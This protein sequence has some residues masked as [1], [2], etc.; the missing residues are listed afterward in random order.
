MG[1]NHMWGEWILVAVYL[2]NCVRFFVTSWTV[3]H[4]APLSMGFSRQGYW[5]GLPLPSPGNL[6]DPG[7][8]PTSLASPA[9][10]GRFF[11]TE[12]PGKPLGWK[13]VRSQ[14]N[15]SKKQDM[16]HIGDWERNLWGWRKIRQVWW[17]RPQGRNVATSQGSS[18][19]S[20]RLTD[21]LDPISWLFV[22]LITILLVGKY[23]RLEWSVLKRKRN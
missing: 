3:P 5:S 1:W 23:R 7:I 18:V 6:P 19:S 12:P 9:L 21:H 20:K 4:Q 11:T 10:A 16:Q 2:L 17:H 8:E 15:K 13:E 22:T 14:K